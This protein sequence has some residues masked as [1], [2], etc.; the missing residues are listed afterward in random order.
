MGSITMSSIT[1]VIDSHKRFLKAKYPKHFQRYCHLLN[2]QSE[3]ARA[4]AIACSF[5]RA[6][7]D[8]VQVE[9]DLQ[10]G[11]VDFRCKSKDGTKFV[12]EVT[13]LEAE[14]A[15][16][17]SKLPNEFP[18]NE[19][20]NELNI[21]GPFAM[22]SHKLLGKAVSKAKQMSGYC[23]SRILVITC[24]HIMASIL[25]GQ[26]GA[27]FL[28]T[29]D[30]EIVEPIDKSGKTS[31]LGNVYSVTDLKNAVFFRRKNGKLESCRR[32]ISAILLLSVSPDQ[33]TSEIFGLLHPDPTHKFPIHALPSVPFLRMRR[34]PPHNGKIEKEWV[35]HEPKP[36]KFYH[37]GCY[38][39]GARKTVSLFK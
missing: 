10:K 30:Q 25:L 23:C 16:A 17:Q 31:K 21:G 34:W 6:K 19:L 7:C 36:D 27:E 5:F 28:L 18:E 14:V 9:E 4:E 26:P 37:H 1:K 13:C 8:D 15:A 12:S 11:G 20:D 2:H 33:K 32:S 22:V 35:I 3:S 29:G 39:M 38:P 24:E